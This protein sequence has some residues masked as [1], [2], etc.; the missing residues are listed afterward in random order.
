M[1][2]S[3]NPLSAIDPN[4]IENVSVL[5]DASATALYGSR[6]ANGVI[7]ITTKKGKYNQKT[8]FEFSTETGSQS[9]A[10]DKLDLMNADEYIKMGGIMMW[11]SQAQLGRTFQTLEQATNYFLSEPTYEG[12]YKGQ[13]TTDW[14]K[15]V[16]RT[17]SVVNTYNFG[18][19]GGG[20]NTS[21][22][23]G[24][25]YYEN[26]PLIKTSGF[27][28]ISINTAID[29]KASEKLKFGINVN[30]SN[31]KRKTYFGGRAS[32]NPSTKRPW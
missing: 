20:A 4:A 30:Y 31:I 12:G 32:A 7:L 6:G 3:W 8:K 25:T 15:A 11:N 28:R 23:I 9:R 19:S 27:N 21:F 13:G 14:V 16:T 17:S 26:S 18:V 29:H 5:K 10:Y 24:G 1:M 2:E 22:R